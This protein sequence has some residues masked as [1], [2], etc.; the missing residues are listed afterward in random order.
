VVFS[1]HDIFAMA[2]EIIAPASFFPSNRI[3]VLVI[4]PLRVILALSRNNSSLQLST[5][6]ANERFFSLNFS[7]A[8]AIASLSKCS[9][10]ASGT[11]Y[12]DQS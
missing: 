5:S 3:A 8:L 10:V 7:R 2:G 4:F 1:T 9:I 12:L 6:L 11:M